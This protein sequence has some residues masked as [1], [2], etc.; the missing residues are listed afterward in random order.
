[1]DLKISKINYSVIARALLCLRNYQTKR[2]TGNQDL[3]KKKRKLINPRIIIYYI[4]LHGS[5][6]SV[7]KYQKIIYYNVDEL[8]NIQ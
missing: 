8:L 1:M 6:L 3:K 2:Y 7:T 5:S 4:F